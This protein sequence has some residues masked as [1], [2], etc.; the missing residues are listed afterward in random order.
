MT[1]IHGYFLLAGRHYFPVQLGMA[2][3]WDPDKVKAAGRATAEEVSLYRC[4]LDVFSC[5]VHRPRYPLGAC[6]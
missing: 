2:V 1:C 5:V 6:G 3:S 4:T